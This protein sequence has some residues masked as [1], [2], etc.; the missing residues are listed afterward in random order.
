MEPTDDNRPLA[1]LT[2][3]EIDR[4]TVAEFKRRAAELT[5][6]WFEENWEHGW[7]ARKL[8]VDALKH[9]HFVKLTQVSE[10]ER[11]VA[12][13]LDKAIITLSGGALVLSVTFLKEIAPSPEFEWM[14]IG[15]WLCLSTSLLTLLLHL[16]SA[17]QALHAQQKIYDRSYKQLVEE[18][19]EAP[20]TDL[21]Q[22]AD[23][24]PSYAELANRSNTRMGV[25]IWA[26]V[27]GI[28]L[29]ALFSLMNLPGSDMSLTR[30]AEDIE[31]PEPAGED[32]SAPAI[33][34][35]DSLQ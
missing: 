31:L 19:V 20:V 3:E 22:Q 28:A 15:S 27:I 18:K 12:G 30:P 2:K 4:M 26:L 32:Q 10:Y 33:T 29:M 5:E 14:L 1:S 23:G 16:P 21:P 13:R 11:E 35:A 8:E 9:E 24:E 7:E 17:I 25:S 6:E 34:P